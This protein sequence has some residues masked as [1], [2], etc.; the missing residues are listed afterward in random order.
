MGIQ[1]GVGRK[2]DGV[3]KDQRWHH[4]RRGCV[5]R[6]VEEEKLQIVALKSQRGGPGFGEDV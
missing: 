2:A 4:K 5:K 6:L 3:E 1:W